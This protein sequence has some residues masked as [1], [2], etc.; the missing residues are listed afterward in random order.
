MRSLGSV[1]LL[2]LPTP[3]S[4][5]RQAGH[6]DKF[7]WKD[8]VHDFT[9]E[10]LAVVLMARALPH[11]LRLWV[12]SPK[13]PS[14]SR[15]AGLMQSL[16]RSISGAVA[17]GREQSEA[18]GIARTGFADWL[19]RTVTGKARAPDSVHEQVGRVVCFD[20]KSNSE[21][22]QTCPGASI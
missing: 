4:S 19:M 2:F 16:H 9:L 21:W 10:H 1:C 18:P 8:P 12:T 20:S 3:P 15:A 17:G 5:L 11:N 6:S 13:S 22:A 7:G 14:S